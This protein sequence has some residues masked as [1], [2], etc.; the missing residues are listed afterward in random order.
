MIIGTVKEVK[1]NEFRV[2]LTPSSV[3]EY[4]HHGHSVFVEKNAGVNSGFTDKDYVLAGAK[5]LNTAE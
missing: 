5:I 1:N 2:G 4:I 3:K